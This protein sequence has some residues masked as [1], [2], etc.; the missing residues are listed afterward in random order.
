MSA[1]SVLPKALPTLS[2]NRKTRSFKLKF[3]C[4]SCCN[5]SSYSLTHLPRKGED[6]P[7]DWR[8][9]S[10]QNR[11]FDKDFDKPST[12]ISTATHGV[13]MGHLASVPKILA[14]ATGRY[15]NGKKKRK[16]NTQMNTKIKTKQNKK[17]TKKQK[18]KIKNKQKETS[19]QRSCY[20]SLDN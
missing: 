20:F 2:S 18:N 5:C 10:E 8:L 7:D 3:S 11:H 16:K 13:S 14:D 15:Y 6:L 4:C 9:A 12:K 19:R 1:A 17:Q